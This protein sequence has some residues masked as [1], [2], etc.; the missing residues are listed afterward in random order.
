M[1]FSVS[2]EEYLQLHS[3][4]CCCSK[5]TRNFSMVFCWLDSGDIVHIVKVLF[6]KSARII[7]IP[8]QWL[9]KQ[10]IQ[11]FLLL[12]MLNNSDEY[13]EFYADVR[14]NLRSIRRLNNS[15]ISRMSIWRVQS[16]H[17]HSSLSPG[18]ESTKSRE[19]QF[20]AN[21]ILSSIAL[22]NSPRNYQWKFQF[23]ALL[24]NKWANKIVINPKFKILPVQPF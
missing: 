9:S 20:A 15:A 13:P 5:L 8:R 10:I 18:I 17:R 24:K 21:L 7:R 23:I 12:W 11:P 4:R 22:T 16:F 14:A 2:V 1:Q 3:E 19:Q 6:P